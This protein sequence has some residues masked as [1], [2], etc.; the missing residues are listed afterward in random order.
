MILELLGAA[1][2]LLNVVEYPLA[3]L[4]V[5]ILIIEQA[6]SRIVVV[7]QLIVRLPNKLHVLV[8]VVAF[9]VYHFLLPLFSLFTFLH[10]LYCL[11]GDAVADGLATSAKYWERIQP[12]IVSKDLLQ[13][14]GRVDIVIAL[15]WL[16][17][18]F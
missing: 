2:V 3:Q 6:L 15:E 7:H 10:A 8:I 14:V 11:P 16:A 13:V 17:L 9:N 12:R 5:P 18:L 4:L 1:L